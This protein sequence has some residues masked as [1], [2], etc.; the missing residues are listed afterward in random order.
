MR[1]LYFFNKFYSRA[2]RLIRTRK[3][4]SPQKVTITFQGE[5]LLE[6][7][8]KTTTFCRLDLTYFPFDVQTCY[9]YFDSWTYSTLQVQHFACK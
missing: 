4:T 8:K 9:I 2:D 6:L 3:K 5:I 7:K 1:L